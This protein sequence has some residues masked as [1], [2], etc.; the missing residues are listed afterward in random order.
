M[1]L[2]AHSN[3]IPLRG[4]DAYRD[5]RLHGKWGEKKGYGAAYSCHKIGLARDF[6]TPNPADHA[7]LH[8]FWDQLGG[9][10]RI[11]ADMGHYSFE[12]QGYR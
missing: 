5:E 4:R 3:G 11:E 9:S 1:I 8:D 10:P 7:F 6:Y 12:W 2:Y